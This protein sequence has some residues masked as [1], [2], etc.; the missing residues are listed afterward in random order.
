MTNTF[1]SRACLLAAAWACAASAGAQ[2]SGAA[3]DPPIAP[4]REIGRAAPP[5]ILSRAIDWAE[6]RIDGQSAARDGFYAEM[7]GMIP[8]AGLSAGPGY[9]RHLAGSGAMLDA[10]M[11]M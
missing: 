2:D 5:S 6:I 11:A 8:G 10:S 9:R 4:Q 7:G 3:G 1:F